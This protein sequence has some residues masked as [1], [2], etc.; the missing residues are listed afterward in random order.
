[1]SWSFLWKIHILKLECIFILKILR[2]IRLFTWL[3]L[4]VVRIDYFGRKYSKCGAINNS[5]CVLEQQIGGICTQILRVSRES[6][7][8]IYI[9]F[10]YEPNAKNCRFFKKFYFIFK[11]YNIVLVLPNIEMNPPQV[12]GGLYDPS[13]KFISL[14]C[15]QIKNT[16]GKLL[17]F[18]VNYYSCMTSF[19]VIFRESVNL[20]QPTFSMK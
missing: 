7:K 1:M 2:C 16:S 19:C 17:V 9:L 18:L 5:I 15:S 4:F 14:V 10:V 8:L 6:D 13:T 12:F 3:F 11:L 20:L